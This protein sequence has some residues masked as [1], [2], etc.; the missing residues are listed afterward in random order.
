MTESSSPWIALAG[1]AVGFLLG[2]GSR[3]MRYRIDIW[4]SKILVKAELRSV[5]AQ[6]PQ[7]CDILNQ[8]IEHMKNQRFMPTVSVRT[9]TLGYYAVQE[10]LYP[11]LKP[12]E[13]NCLHVIFERLR[14]ADEQMDEFESSFMRA[15]KDKIPTD[16]WGTFIGRCEE[17]LASYAVVEHLAQSYLAGKPEDVFARPT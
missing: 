17:L 4:R 6:L 7:K 12:I 5:I 8:A 16:P 10:S 2:E 11:H 1:V 15:I 9:V 14:I 13:R 3:Y